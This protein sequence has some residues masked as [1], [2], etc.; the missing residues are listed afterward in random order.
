MHPTIQINKRHSG[1]G[2]RL[3]PRLDKDARAGRDQRENEPH[4]R[5]GPEQKGSTTDAAGEEG[6]GKRARE[7]EHLAGRCDEG[8]FDF[9]RDAGGLE[10]TAEVVAHKAIAGPLFANAFIASQGTA[11]LSL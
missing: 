6:K 11:R 4:Q 9:L 10:H 8:G 7:A 3:T 5:H 1:I 2:S